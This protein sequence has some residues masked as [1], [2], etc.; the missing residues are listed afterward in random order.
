MK[1]T[2]NA[3][4]QISYSDQLPLLEFRMS[5]WATIN[6]YQMPEGSCIQLLLIF[7]K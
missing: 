2:H 7:I 5:I 6:L 3:T 1:T 4:V